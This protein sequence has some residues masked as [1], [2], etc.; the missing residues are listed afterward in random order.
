MAVEKE[1]VNWKA[2][3]DFFNKGLESEDTEEGE[4]EDEQTLEGA[5]GDDDGGGEGGGED[6]H[7]IKVRDLVEISIR[8]KRVRVTKEAAE[9]YREYI[10]RVRERDSRHG[11]EI[12]KLRETLARLEGRVESG[13]ISRDDEPQAPTPPD[14]AL[15]RTNWEAYH[16]Q[17]VAY[18]NAMI[19]HTKLELKREYQTERAR[20]SDDERRV[21]ENTRWVRGFFGQ[22]EELSDP[23]VRGIVQTVYT[24]HGAEI[25][26]IAGVSTQE[27]YDRL[28][29]LTNERLV[30][31]AV[32][33]KQ[34]KG[35]TNGRKQP[36]K[37]EGGGSAAQR[38]DD[39][40]QK[41]Q[42]FSIAKWQS[43]KRAA[44]RGDKRF[45]RK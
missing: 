21:A 24:E 41:Q 9:A 18:Q 7:G 23:N 35:K 42:P 37:V 33:G 31:L 29:E 8:G 40:G 5:D 6:D 3:E 32:R 28:A 20:E 25:D 10:N 30:A 44:M 36:P 15:A 19:A 34:E 38:R 16:Q 26:S 22:Y 1:D 17:L 39:G 14:P 13:R 12:S 43:D 11:G 2:S 4:Q 45:D 27:A